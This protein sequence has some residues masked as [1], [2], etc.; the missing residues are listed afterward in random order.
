MNINMNLLQIRQIFNDICEIYQYTFN[1][2]EMI[3]QYI[4]EI[5]IDYVNF[6]TSD[7][8]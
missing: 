5:M 3:Q 8:H 1:Q 4:I 6:M 2:L 7:I